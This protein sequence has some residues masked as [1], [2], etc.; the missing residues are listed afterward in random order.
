MVLA[1]DLD[2]TLANERANARARSNYIISFPSE[3]IESAG[4][5]PRVRADGQTNRALAR[6][7]PPSWK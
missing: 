5:R 6:A 3:G 4:E 1:V 2:I 7:I